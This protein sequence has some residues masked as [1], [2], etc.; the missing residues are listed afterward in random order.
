MENLFLHNK[1]YKIAIEQ[2]DNNPKNLR[3]LGCNTIPGI[4]GF[5][6]QNKGLGRSDQIVYG[7]R[8]AI[9]DFVC[10]TVAEGM[11]VSFAS[12]ESYDWWSNLGDHYFE[13]SKN[14]DSNYKNFKMKS[15]YMI[16]GPIFEDFY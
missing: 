16:E 7:I 14:N 10:D 12:M 15:G 8:D 1:A 13:T 11:E 6:V 3:L 9:Y 5:I 4:Y 2:L